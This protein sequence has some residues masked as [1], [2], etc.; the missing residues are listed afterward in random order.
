RAV[1]GVGTSVQ[2]CGRTDAN[3]S[4][5]RGRRTSCA[6]T[7]TTASRD[8]SPTTRYHAPRRN[9]PPVAAPFTRGHCCSITESV[10]VADLYDGT[11]AARA[12]CVTSRAAGSRV[13]AQRVGNVWVRCV[14]DCGERRAARGI[15]WVR[16]VLVC[17]LFLPMILGAQQPSAP[18]SPD[19]AV[20]VGTV[21]DTLSGAPIRL[22]AVRLLEATG[23]VLTD[24]AGRYRG[25]GAPGDVAL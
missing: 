12:S 14:W 25:G 16:R 13:F 21:Y 2:V 8:V 18:A 24:D 17:L 22:A 9:P 3:S 4:D 1:A 15:A 19:S 7:A 11:L 20:I 10:V 23:S 6:S 5:P